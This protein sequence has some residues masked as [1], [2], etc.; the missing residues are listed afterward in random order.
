MSAVPIAQVPQLSDVEQNTAKRLFNKLQAFQSANARQDAYYEGSQ[1]VRDLGISIPPHLRTIETVVGWPGMAVDVLEER[2]DHDGW[3][4]PGVSGDPLGI[5]QIVDDNRLDVEFNAGHLD[6]LIYGISFG[7]AAGGGR[8]EPDPLVTVESPTRMTA[9]WDR[10]RRAVSEAMLVSTN[11][12]G[13][14]DGATLWLPEVV[15]ELRKSDDRWTLEDRRRNRLGRPPVVRLANRTRA[16]DTTGRSEITRAVRALTNNAVRTVL[17]MEIAREFFSSPQR[18]IMGA[19]ETSF[20]DA[21]GNAKTAWETYL[22][23]VLAL[24]ADEHG[25][26]PEVGTFP[27]SSPSPYGEQLRVLAQM[28]AAET[29]LPVKY[30]GLVHDSNPAS[31]DAALIDESRLNKRTERRQRSFGAAEGELLRMA[32]HIR[33]GADPGV[34]PRPIW[35]PAAT[36]TLAAAA[37]ATMKL[38]SAKILPPDSE[39]TYR[40][41]GLDD[42]EIE[43]L[44]DEK[45][46]DRA[47]QTV[48]A[49]AE[50]AGQARQD[51]QVAELSDR[52]DPA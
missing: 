16:G 24:S 25:N 8:G 22:G 28:V 19:D 46:R 31:A 23:R 38:V 37:D 33:D 14:V 48:T 41:I 49:L 21:D 39:L 36:P 47:R 11:S 18:W 9:T 45:R 50:A 2:L 34:T 40:R 20:Q 12:A 5:S 35:R 29:A 43:R 10:R 30:L 44:R 32:L 26:R 15:L 3:S 13:T 17:G 6:A 7:V 27:A 42:R 4:T 51:P 1:R 52:R